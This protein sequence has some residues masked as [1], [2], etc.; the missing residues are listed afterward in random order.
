MFAALLLHTSL[1]QSEEAIVEPEQVPVASARPNILLVLADDLGFSDLGS[2][3]SEI[4]TPTLDA[5][6][7]EG[8][9]FTN[10]HTA[11]NCAPARAMLLTGV[12][13]HLAGVP[14][15][16][17]M[18]AP[19]QQRHSH[20][21]GV[22][23]SN[24]VTVATLLEGAGY[25][26]YM[27][28]KWHLGVGDGQ[29]PSQRGFQRTIAL[30]DSG[31]DNWEQ[32]PYIPLYEKANWYADGKEYQLPDDFY[33]SRFLVDKAI[34][35][36]DSN[37]DDGQPFFAYLPFQA[38]HI[39]VQAPQE[40]ID[41]YM[42]VY[43]GGWDELREQRLARAVELGIVPAG[44]DMVQMSTTG[45]W[46]ALDA[47]QRRYEAKR[48]AVYGAM[49]EAM[50][51][52]LGRL[53]HYLKARGQYENT[54][55]IFTSDN[56]AEASGPA[57]PDSLVAR[58]GPEA[59]GY[60]TDYESLGLKGSYNTISP[61]FASA[62]AS[63]LA[64]YKFYAGEGGMRVPLIVAGAGLP[65]QGEL[66]HAFSFVTDITPTILS[67]TGVAAPEGRFGGRPVEPMIGRDLK[68][69]LKQE[70]T[71]VY[72]AED[73]VG[74]EL[75]GHAALFQ[76][77]YKLLSIRPPLGDGQWR[78]Y[79]IVRDPGETI[80]LA[81]E[82]PVRLQRM[83]SAYAVY[84]RDNKVLAN[85]PGYDHMKQLVINTLYQRLQTP[86]LVGLLTA[87]ILLPFLVAYRARRKVQ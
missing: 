52:H 36:I 15:I 10:Y 6:A 53:F 65:G 46:D 82:Q 67:L 17:E 66:N 57:D 4:N 29:L 56:G 44:I 8:V 20:Y 37:L 43:D 33:S 60:N 71:R 24:V 81:A 19:E 69:L 35:F 18:L 3:G 34:E 74:Y 68:P 23:G 32:R 48:M 49:V 75:A 54:I 1:G 38:V 31:A 5:L 83:L 13:A 77:D 64:Y 85:P 30:A 27:A 16:P 26:T 22:L 80:D 28:G 39:P 76:G 87:L 50:D 45:D 11:A 86:V 73:A 63:P 25:H 14:N 41:R 61:S 47:G 79:D 42:G 9:R 40:F 59:L 78:L 12:D 7:Q 84:A 72:G 2:Y 70:V 51:F 21:Q 55:V 62:A 58:R